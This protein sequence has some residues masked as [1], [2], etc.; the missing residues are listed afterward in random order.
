MSESPLVSIIMPVYN[1]EATLE[2]S[3]SSA[4]SQEKVNLELICINDGS[5]DSS[6]AILDAWAARDPRIRII[7][8]DNAGVAAARNCGLDVLHGDYFTL[9][10]ADDRIAPGYLATLLQTAREQHADAVITGWTRLSGGS[11]IPHHITDTVSLL[12]TSAPTIASLP[13]AAW[14]RLYSTRLL[15][16]CA[17]RYPVGVRYGED[18]AFNFAMNAAAHRIICHP[19]VGYYYLDNPASASNTCIGEK[20]TDMP[21]ALAALAETYTAQGMDPLRQEL[22]AH[23]AAQAL[24]RIRSMAPHRSQHDCARRI[25][26]IL[27]QAGVQ[28]AHL[29]TLRSK[30]ARALHCILRGGDGLQPGYYWRRLT[31]FLR[32]KA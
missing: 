26:T 30:D 14:G 17:A 32:G 1:A 31:R 5:R 12:E 18:M 10:D 9:L 21:T 19:S 29:S 28:E 2:S 23:F 22:L 6:A 24:R 11:G 13:P 3:L 4:Y 27:S 25:S 20:V 15:R 8:Q 7:H 16:R